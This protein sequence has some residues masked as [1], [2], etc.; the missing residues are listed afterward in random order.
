MHSEVSILTMEIRGSLYCD[1]AQPAFVQEWIFFHLQNKQPFCLAMSC[2]RA[3]TSRILSQS[4]PM[5]TMAYRLV[6]P[7]TRVGDFENFCRNASLRLW[8]GSVEMMRTWHHIRRTKELLFSLLT[9]I[10]YSRCRSR[11]PL[12]PKLGILTVG[13]WTKTPNRA[14]L[15]ANSG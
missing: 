13:T 2:R 3:F 8:A 10:F 6:N 9:S 15:L 4:S 11:S 5:H 7:L 12:R 14:H 1:H